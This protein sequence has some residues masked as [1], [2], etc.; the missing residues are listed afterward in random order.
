MP[1][2]GARQLAGRIYSGGLRLPTLNENDGHRPPL[3][4][5]G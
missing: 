4:S 2:R 1:A 3:Q 5:S